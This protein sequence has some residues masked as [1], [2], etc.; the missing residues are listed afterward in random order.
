MI[1]PENINLPD[2]LTLKDLIRIAGKTQRQLS[3]ETGIPER[4]VYSWTSGEKMPRLDHAF[5]VAANLGVPLEVLAKSL[6]IKSKD[7][8][9]NPDEVADM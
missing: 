8:T 6:G 7:L 3:R 2:D 9:I 5:L 4:T 1:D